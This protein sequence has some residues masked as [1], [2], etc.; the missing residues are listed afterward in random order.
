MAKKVKGWLDSFP[1]AQMGDTYPLDASQ[2]MSTLSTL[3]EVFSAPQKSAT[4][5]IT[6][7]YQA[8]SEALGITNP[9][10]QFA[11]DMVLDPLNIGIAPLS[12]GAYKAGKAL[13]PIVDD[14]IY[15][16]F[17]APKTINKL[18]PKNIKREL[19]ERIGV[20]EGE[21]GQYNQGVYNLKRFPESVVKFENPLAIE[22]DIEFQNYDKFNFVDAMK[23]IPDNSGIAK[24]RHQFPLEK[25]SSA[26]IM[27][28]VDGV[29]IERVSPIQLRKIPEEAIKQ[30]YQ[31]VKTLRNN[32]LGMDFIGNNIVYSPQTK[33]FGLFDIDPG[34]VGEYWMDD[35]HQGMSKHLGEDVSA[36]NIK[37][38]LEHKLVN[39]YWSSVDKN[40]IEPSVD[41][42]YLDDQKA[43]KLLVGGKDFLRERLQKILGPLDSK[44]SGGNIPGSVGFTYARTQSPAPSNGKYAKKTMSSAQNGGEMKFYQ[45]GLDW[46]PKNISRD[47]KVIEDNL[48]QWKHPG[49]ITKINSNQITMKGVDY[50]VLGISNTGDA[51]MMF[52]NQEYSYKGD[53]VTEYPMMQEGGTIAM[54]KTTIDPR[55]WMD[56]LSMVQKKDGSIGMW[57]NPIDSTKTPLP[58]QQLNP[59]GYTDHR[60]VRSGQKYQGSPSTSKLIEL[61]EKQL[62]AQSSRTSYEDGGWLQKFI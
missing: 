7:K 38:A 61:K 1:Q 54:N 3:G 27:D 16:N 13:M 10:G 41:Q 11:T 62:K 57:G 35:V 58:I 36:N 49:E 40:I 55:Q 60:G 44:Q 14:F 34:D 25:N 6:G 45:E 17:R 53:S 47:G 19:G 29:P 56:A 31:N 30:L 2:A 52:P 9:Y 28:K 39:K 22:R 8:P 48:G 23:N 5:L 33:K 59:I 51:Q 37:K 12:K 50:P 32:N 43:E 24:V 42:R 26:L 21:G 46:K 20:G 4:K 18:S 15:E